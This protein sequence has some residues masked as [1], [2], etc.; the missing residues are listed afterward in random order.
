MR[1]KRFRLPETKSGMLSALGS[2]PTPKTRVRQVRLYLIGSV[3]VGGLSR[4]RDRG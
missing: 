2:R 4:R 1:A 3:G